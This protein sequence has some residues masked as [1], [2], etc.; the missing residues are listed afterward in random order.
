MG[1][2]AEAGS[3]IRVSLG[4]NT[5]RPEVEAFVGILA[6]VVAGVRGAAA[7]PLPLPGRR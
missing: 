4:P 1:L 5:T 7:V 3:S 2:E 6:K